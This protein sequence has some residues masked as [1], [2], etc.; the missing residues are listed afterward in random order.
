MVGLDDGSALQAG[1]DAITGAIS[2]SPS[3]RF[4][5]ARPVAVSRVT[6]EGSPSTLLLSSRPWIG[7]GSSGKGRHAMAP[8][9]YTPLDHGCSFS[10][11]AVRE[12]IV[13]TSGNTLRILSI[14]DSGGNEIG[15]G[16][17]DDEAFN[18][19]RVDLRYTPRQMCLLSARA[20]GAESSNVSHSRRILL[21][22]VE[23]DYNDFG[24]A[25]KKA[26]GFDGTGQL[27]KAV[28][29]KKDSDVTKTGDDEAM[30][31]DEDSDDDDA[32]IEEKKEEG[33][34][35]DEDE[36][37]QTRLTPIRGPFPAEQGHWGSCVR[38]VDPSDACVTL[39]CVEMNR[40]EAALC[41]ASVRFHSRG[42]E[43]L[44]AV[45][46]VTGMT[47]HPLLFSKSIW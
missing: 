9:S 16:A 11:E 25:D 3:R 7:R 18:S 24:E 45:G 36:D 13:A 4:L 20:T 12:G 10:N 31:M 5:G 26:M 40:N 17:E 33:N 27:S 21:A 1:V 15:L 47:M 30:D 38:L 42:G 14:G 22:L 37:N 43:S 8:M 6:L 28:S 41:C 35:E 19:T 23:S 2:T 34:E 32:K 46:T 44:L 39:D 29:K